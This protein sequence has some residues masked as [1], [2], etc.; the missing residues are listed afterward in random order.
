MDG[1]GFVDLPNPG[2]WIGD[3]SGMLT[4]GMASG[5]PNGGLDLLDGETYAGTPLAAG[6]LCFGP[7]ATWGLPFV[8]GCSDQNRTYGS[9]GAGGN[10]SDNYLNPYFF[11]VPGTLSSYSLLDSP[12]GVLLTEANNK[13]FAAAFFSSA[14]RDANPD[15]IVDRGYDM[16]EIVNGDDNPAAPTG[17]D[18]IVPWQPIPQPFISATIDPNNNRILSFEWSTIR[19][20][21]DA[22]TRLNPNALVDAA[23]ARFVLGKDFNNN[24]LTGVGVLEQ[25]ELVSYIVE[26]K[27]IVGIDCDPVAPWTAAGPGVIQLT[28]Q[29]GGQ[30]LTTSVT[31]P[32]DTC[33]RLTTRFGRVPSE[34]FAPTPADM[35]TRN[36][37]RFKAQAGNLGDV[38]YEVSS[39]TKIVGGN[40]LSDRPVLRSAVMNQRNLVV[41][42]ET[43]GEIELQDFD[44]LARDRRGNATVVATVQCTECSSG[45]GAEY[46]VEVPR[47]ALKAAASIFVIAHPSETE[48]NELEIQRATGRPQTSGRG[49]TG[50]A[51]SR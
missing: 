24:N 11:G 49:A 38:G 21:H 6:G 18:N 41:K 50:K 36:Q 9:L 16:G 27:P 48:S 44:V 34:T 10:V 32:Q 46:V 17:N 23:A 14:P 5:E 28:A 2:I 4:S 13:Y 7:A 12:M 15:D 40:L 35:A 43:L 1:D 42:F 37:N 47:T 39:T 22:S 31:V 20:I 51:A 19:I 25:P 30:P 3:D 8:D 45:I 33:V 26:R 29:P